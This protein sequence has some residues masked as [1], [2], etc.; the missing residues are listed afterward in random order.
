[1]YSCTNGFIMISDTSVRISCSISGCI[2]Y[3]SRAWPVI[4]GACTAYD[5][6]PVNVDTATGYKWLA[7]GTVIDVVDFNRL[8]CYMSYFFNTGSA[9]IS[10]VV[11]NVSVIDY[12]CLMDYVHHTCARRIIVVDIRAAYI[13][14]RRANPVIIGHVKV[15]A[16]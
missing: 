16:K 15:I 8:A 7:V 14:L 2:Y 3:S 4:A 1:M 12:S 5:A 13:G 10:Y 11:V 6:R 9:H